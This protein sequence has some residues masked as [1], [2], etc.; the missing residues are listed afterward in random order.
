MGDQ[1]SF[2]NNAFQTFLSEAPQ[3]AQA[4]DMR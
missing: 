1:P 2:I 4:W 3:H